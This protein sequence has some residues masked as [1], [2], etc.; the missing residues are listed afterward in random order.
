MCFL[1]VADST[2][3]LAIPAAT[4]D[5]LM[6]HLA[7]ERME[8]IAAGAKGS[9][10]QITATSTKCKT[11]LYMYIEYT[12]IGNTSLASACFI[13]RDE[14]RHPLRGGRAV[15]L[16]TSVECNRRKRRCEKP[17]VRRAFWKS[18]EV[19]PLLLK[20]FLSKPGREDL[21]LKRCRVRLLF[22]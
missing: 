19:Q 14:D 17:R 7:E 13:R 16:L 2:C 5:T 12:P 22:Y 10:Q 9:P 11:K 6:K 18:N 15:E 4:D 20:A 3:L 8:R 1:G 21:F